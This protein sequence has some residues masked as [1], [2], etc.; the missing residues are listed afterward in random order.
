MR[1][2]RQE[3]LTIRGELT[4]W[5]AFGESWGIGT[6]RTAVDT[7]AI[8]GTLAGVRVG[9]AVELVGSWT[10]HPKYGLQFKAKSCTATVPVSTDGIVAWLASTL[11]DVGDERARRL[12][13]R[14]GADLWKVI[15]TAHEALASVEGITPRRA[16][17]IRDAYFKNKADR[18]NMIQLRGWGLT[19]NQVGR[20]VA[21]WGDLTT[22]VQ[23]VHANPY[24]LSQYV[25]GFGFKRADE[26]ATKAG[27]PADAPERVRAG[28][29]YLL[30]EA[31]TNGHCFMA[32]AA[33]QKLAA[34]LLGV[35]LGKVAVAIRALAAEGRIALRQ[36]RIYPT[37]LDVAEGAVAAATKRL[38]E[39][40]DYHGHE[41]H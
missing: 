2:L 3:V 33:L 18:D 16:E 17:A 37:R 34:K 36:W 23:R 27:V 5:R 13:E 8:T 41:T 38:I 30:E 32:G 4:S 28:V 25:Y 24:Q 1:T 29:A 10:T 12:V 40:N 35:D 22:V 39:R 19:D 15:E 26:V 14:F 7:I 21:Q 31:G 11:P 6:V 9:A 20:C